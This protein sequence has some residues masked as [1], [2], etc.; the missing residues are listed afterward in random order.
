VRHNGVQ[1]RLARREQLAPLLAQLAR[2]PGPL[3][4]DSLA[5]QLSQI[6]AAAVH[7]AQRGLPPLDLRAEAIHVGSPGHLAPPQRLKHRGEVILEPVVWGNLSYLLSGKLNFHG[8]V[9]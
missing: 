3:D 6:I 4:D 2:P 9:L 7:V 1:V 8:G 5:L